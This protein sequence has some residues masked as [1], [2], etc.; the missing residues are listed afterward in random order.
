MNK[1]YVILTELDDLIFLGGIFDSSALANET[2]SKYPINASVV[3]I[4]LNEDRIKDTYG[5][6]PNA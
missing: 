6:D 5:I 1:V 2:L 3:E 4:T